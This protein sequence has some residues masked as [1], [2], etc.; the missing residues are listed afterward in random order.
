[1]SDDPEFTEPNRI[2]LSDNSNSEQ[3]PDPETKDMAEAQGTTEKETQDMKGGAPTGEEQQ[4]EGGSEEKGM[5]RIFT[6]SFALRFRLH[7]YS[8]TN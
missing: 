5:R 6:P 2:E 8:P 3:L 4:A 7:L 1:M